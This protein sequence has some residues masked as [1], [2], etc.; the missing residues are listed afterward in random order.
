MDVQIVSNVVV[1]KAELPESV[2]E[3]AD[4]RTGRPH[5]LRQSLLTKSGDRHF[6]HSFFSELRHQQ[7]NPRQPLFAGVEKLIDQIILVSNVSL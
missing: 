7:E 4:P 6:G 1:D 2:H 3:K 5:H